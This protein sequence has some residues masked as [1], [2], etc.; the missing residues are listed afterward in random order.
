MLWLFLPPYSPDYNT[1]EE[2][3]S[4]F[5]PQ[6]RS[7]DK[8][9]DADADADV[10]VCNDPETPVLSA[11]SFKTAQDCQHWIEHASI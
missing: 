11:F 5:K 7:M 2:A 3:F 9:A 8:K 10:D 4:K 1:I 6:L